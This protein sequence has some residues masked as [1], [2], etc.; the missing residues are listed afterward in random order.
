MRAGIWGAVG[1]ART[2]VVK[3]GP[4]V[5]WDPPWWN[6]QGV[7]GSFSSAW[8]GVRGASADLSLHTASS[9]AVPP[10]KGLQRGLWVSLEQG[11]PRNCPM[12]LRSIVLLPRGCS[13]QSHPWN[14]HHSHLLVPSCVLFK[15]LGS[16]EGI[17]GSANRLCR[18][19]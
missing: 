15:V 4:C 16:L 6:D 8:A 7:S 18:G 12:E 1:A 11:Q 3:V 13:L 9:G 19:I 2:S 10:M 5:T 17:A 14:P